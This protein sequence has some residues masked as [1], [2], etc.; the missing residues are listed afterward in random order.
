MGLD[1][2]A[3][4]LAPNPGEIVSDETALVCEI[5]SFD[6]SKFNKMFTIILNFTR[7][8]HF[9]LQETLTTHLLTFSFNILVFID[10]NLLKITFINK[11]M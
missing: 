11:S 1:S 4:P 9:I 10:Y 8:V 5:V 3:Q 6:H 7:V 2:L